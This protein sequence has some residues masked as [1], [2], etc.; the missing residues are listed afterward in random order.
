LNTVSLVGGAEDDSP[1]GAV[2][3]EQSYTDCGIGTYG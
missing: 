3:G 1:D 2:V